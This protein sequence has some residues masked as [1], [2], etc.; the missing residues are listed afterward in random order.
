MIGAGMALTGACPGTVLVQA[1]VGIPS[2]VPVFLGALAGG[3]AYE[4]IAPLHKQNANEIEDTVSSKFHLDPN[5]TL[6]AFEALLLSAVLAFSGLQSTPTGVLNPILGG[7]AVGVAQF[8]SIALSNTP[9]GVS[10]AFGD[11]GKWFW[12]TVDYVRG[13]HSGDR[14]KPPTSAI[15]FVLSLMAGAYLLTNLRPDFILKGSPASISPLT[16]FLG[17]IVLILGARIAGGC[18]SGHGISGM[19]LLSISSIVSVAAMFGSGIA[20]GLALHR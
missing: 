13:K 4:A 14:P 5:T 16:G 3:I 17:G 11:F 12:W 10:S 2:A 8:G 1:A 6:I 7:L 20:V 15:Q 9:L 19:A 18:T